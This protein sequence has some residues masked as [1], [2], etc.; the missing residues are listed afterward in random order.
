MEM[1]QEEALLIQMSQS[2]RIVAATSAGEGRCVQLSPGSGEEERKNSASSR[3]RGET[4]WSQTVT[5]LL[6]EPHGSARQPHAVLGTGQGWFH[7]CTASAARSG[8]FPVPAQLLLPP[9]PQRAG[10]A[11]RSR[12]MP[13]A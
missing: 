12:W 7:L 1:V 13:H 3:N 9:R 2:R 6:E 5:S 11:C 4:V 10:A 8:C